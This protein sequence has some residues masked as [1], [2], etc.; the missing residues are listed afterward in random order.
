MAHGLFDLELKALGDIEVDFHHTVED[1]GICL[2]QAY[3]KAIDDGKGIYRYASN[4]IPMDE[5]LCYIAIDISGRPYFEWN[6]TFLESKKAV[7][8]AEMVEVFLQAF[9][10]N[11]KITLHVEMLRGTNLHHML[12]ACF[13]GIGITLDNA[14]SIDERK[15]N[16]IP[17]TKGILLE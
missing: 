2:G 7:F 1:I 14:S 12:E 10:D 17:S 9:V 4:L 13:K 6:R 16:D 8:D 5:A 15:K 11:A 3:R